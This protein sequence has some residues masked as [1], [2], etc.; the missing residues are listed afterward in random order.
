MR[1]RGGLYKIQLPKILVH[2][3]G[4]VQKSLWRFLN[5]LRVIDVTPPPAPQSSAGVESS[6]WYFL[7]VPYPEFLF[8]FKDENLFKG[9]GGI[10][11]FGSC[12]SSLLYKIEDLPLVHIK[13]LGKQIVSEGLEAPFSAFWGGRCLWTCLPPTSWRW[14][15]LKNSKSLNCFKLS[16]CP[17]VS[18]FPGS[19]DYW[20]P[21]LIYQVNDSKTRKEL[22]E[23][24][25]GK[26][27]Q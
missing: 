5:H 20:I 23:Q 11:S 10:W 18:F 7:A 1:G 6:F 27:K 12:R 14:P 4:K 25:K 22:M 13:E 17:L 15:S 9:E 21:S 19:W 16:L 24:L 8:E 2:K 26:W 3:I